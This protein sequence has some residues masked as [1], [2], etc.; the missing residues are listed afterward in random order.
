MYHVGGTLDGWGVTFHTLDEQ[1]VEWNEA[2]PLRGY[3]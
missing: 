3:S 2:H 1:G